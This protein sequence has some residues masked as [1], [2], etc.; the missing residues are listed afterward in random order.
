MAL[1][2]SFQLTEHLLRAC[3][4]NDDV[5]IKGSVSDFHSGVSILCELAS[6][7]LVQLSEEHA[8]SNKLRPQKAPSPFDVGS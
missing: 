8:I 6:Q 7:H 3:R 1:V 2:R 5:H 4:S